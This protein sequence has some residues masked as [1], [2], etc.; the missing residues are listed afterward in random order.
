MGNKDNRFNVL[1]NPT[2]LREIGYAKQSNTR[3]ALS[4][5]KHIRPCKYKQIDRNSIRYFVFAEDE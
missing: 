4:R 2:R 3:T 5:S 1:N